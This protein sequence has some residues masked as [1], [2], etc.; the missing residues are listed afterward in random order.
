MHERELA[1]LC[2]ELALKQ[3]LGDS[4]GLQ[5]AQSAIAACSDR[6]A[7]GLVDA[8]SLEEQSG[9][10]EDA[11]GGKPPNLKRIIGYQWALQEFQKFDDLRNRAITLMAK[12][13]AMGR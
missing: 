6:N 1:P 12:I 10:D 9:G 3:Q 5:Q 2:T 13:D 8:I 4:D 7:Q 11:A